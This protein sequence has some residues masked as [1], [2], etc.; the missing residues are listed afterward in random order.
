[1]ALVQP[2]RINNLPP[3]ILSRIFVTIVDASLYARSIGDDNYGSSEYPTLISSVCAYWRRVS[4]SIPRLWHY[5]DL[6][7]KNVRPRNYGHVQLWLE[8]S[9]NLPLQLRVGKGG[10]RAEEREGR[11]G[12]GALNSPRRMDDQLAS[13]LLS[14]APRLH[15]FTLKFSYP[16]FAAEILAWLLTTGQHSVR[17]LALRQSRWLTTRRSQLLPQTKW[18][19]LLEPL[20]VLH[21]ERIDIALNNIPCRNLVELQL[22]NPHAF[23]LAQ[24]IQLLESNPGLRTIMLDGSFA[25]P[26]SSPTTRPINLPSLRSVHLATG[27]DFIISLFKLL[28]P[29]PH[30][31]DLQLRY[32]KEPARVMETMIPFFQRANV[33]SLYLEAEEAT[34]LPILTAL[35]HLQSLGLSTFNF[36]ASTFAG[37]ESAADLLPKLHTIDL[38][39]CNFDDYSGLYPGLRALLSLPSMRRI[40]HLN[41]G[42]WN[43]NEIRERVVQLLEEGEF[44]ATILRA[45]ASDFEARPSPFR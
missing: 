3:E 14:S 19:Q 28:V 44:A 4:I 43:S 22:I 29:G 23:S 13:V 21:L 40:R 6:M 1:M 15:S 25:T 24:F 9:Q 35:P 20:H 37:L 30:E 32:H 8:R 41:C 18:N 26:R 38:N 12:M 34:L 36:D 31:L 39:E 2:A 7:P 11:S 45:S 10:E 33:K 17:E 5:I 16:D 42:E 27:Q